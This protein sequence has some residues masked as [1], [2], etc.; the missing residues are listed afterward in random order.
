VTVKS[1]TIGD[2][3]EGVI[4]GLPRSGSTLLANILNQ[5]EHIYA[6]S[7]SALTNALLAVSEVFTVAPECTSDLANIP[8]TAETHVKILREMCEGWH[9][10]TEDI[11]LDKGRGWSQNLT[12][13]RRMFPN[14]LAIT[15]VRDPRDV[16]ASIEK[17]HRKTGQYGP[18]GTLL[19]RCSAQMSAEGIVG[20]AILGVEDALRRSD[21]RVFFINYTA[22]VS[23]PEKVL[24]ALNESLGIEYEY[25]LDNVENSSSDLDVLYRNKFPHHGFGKIEVPEDEHWS[26]FISADIAEETMKLYPLFNETFG[27][28]AE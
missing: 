9:N 12:L 23:D 1:Q 2:V 10:R 3:M 7:T 21:D 16:L 25:D 24:A 28:S 5:N 20:S 18:N 13:L 4:T 6:S 8:D 26:Q 14:S 27:Y 19:E 17:Q 11:I 22:L 15:T